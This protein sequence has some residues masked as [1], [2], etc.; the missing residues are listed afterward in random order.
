MVLLHDQML[1]APLLP[2]ISHCSACPQPPLTIVLLRAAPSAPAWRFLPWG[3][4]C[5]NVGKE[6]TG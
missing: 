2:A 3:F 1:F 5:Y 6:K 4:R